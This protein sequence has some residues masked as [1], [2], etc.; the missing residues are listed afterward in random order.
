[1][2]VVRYEMVLARKIGLRGGYEARNR[3]AAGA[4]V[5]S[6]TLGV[7]ARRAARKAGGGGGGLTEVVRRRNKE[8]GGCAARNRRANQ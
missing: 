7:R 8:R 3:G 2:L 4:G 5:K 6:K 1:V